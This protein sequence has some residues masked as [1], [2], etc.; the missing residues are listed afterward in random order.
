MNGYMD[1]WIYGY[2]DIWIYRYNFKKSYFSTDPFP[3]LFTKIKMFLPTPNI[4]LNS[5]LLVLFPP[6]HIYFCQ[7]QSTRKD[8]RG[9]ISMLLVHAGILAVPV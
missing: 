8:K 3:T 7:I 1:I 9:G 5:I 2:M 6:E 4:F